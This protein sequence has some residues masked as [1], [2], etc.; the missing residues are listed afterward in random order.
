MK[1]IHL[2]IKGDAFGHEWF[3]AWLIDERHEND[4]SSN[5]AAELTAYTLNSLGSYNETNEQIY[6]ASRFEPQSLDNSQMEQGINQL[7]QAVF[8][9]VTIEC[10]SA[11]KLWFK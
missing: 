4:T 2:I 11:I 5:N 7:C 6:S 3:P 1:Y 10:Q 9:F 8:S